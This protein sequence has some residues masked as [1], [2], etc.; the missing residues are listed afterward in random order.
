MSCACTKTIGL[1][2]DRMRLCNVPGRKVHI[3]VGH[4]L[5]EGCLGGASRGGVP[6]PHVPIDHPDHG[7]HDPAREEHQDL[8]RSASASA[9]G[10]G[11]DGASIARAATACVV[12]VGA[13]ISIIFVVAEMAAKVAGSHDA[14]AVCRPRIGMLLCSNGRVKGALVLGIVSTST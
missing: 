1:G 5:T 6:R 2:Y 13:A 11:S 9:V 10:A 4:E 14:I 8:E 12:T 3:R 7:N